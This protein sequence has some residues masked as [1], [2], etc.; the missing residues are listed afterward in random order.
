MSR[1]GTGLT[2]MTNGTAAS[3]TDKPLI[4]RTTGA[5]NVRRLLV[6][7]GAVFFLA[8]FPALLGHTYGGKLLLAIFA[9]LAIVGVVVVFA[10]ALGLVSVA[11]QPGQGSIANDFL[12][13]LDVGTLIVDRRGRIVYANT[14]YGRTVGASD[15]AEIRT[16]ERLLS[17]EREASEAIYRLA[18]LARDNR[19]GQ[20]EFRLPRSLAD[21]G[22]PAP[23]WY[24]VSVRP[25]GTSPNGL[26]AWQ[27]ADV[28][29]ERDDQETF[30]QDLQHAIDYLD[31]APAGFFAADAEGRIA[32]INATL[33]DWLGVDLVSFRPYA[34]AISEFAAGGDAALLSTST[35]ATD[36]DAVS[37][38]DLDLVRQ[39]GDRLPVRLLR[40]TGLLPDGAPGLSR[41]I[42]LQRNLDATG[43]GALD[44]AEV[45]FTRFF[46]SSPMAIAALG[47]DGRVL[48]ANAAFA[49][50]FGQAAAG[51]LLSVGEAVRDDSRD[52]LRQAL[53]AAGRQEAG[54][55]AVDVDLAG[56]PVRCARLYI[57]ATGEAG[58]GSG[59]TAILYGVDITDQRSLE[60][61]FAKSQK[62]QAVG[63]LAGG[64]AHDFN[65][66]LTIITASVDF[67]L[68]NH[69]SG[70]P[71]FQDLLLIKQSA[72]RA[73]SLVR[74]LLA[75]SR[76]QTMRPKMLNLTDVIADM[77]LLLKRI[78]G[79]L[80]K[81]ERHH[82]R[83][84]WP[85]MAD[86]G[87][88]EQVI[89]N[90]VQNARDAMPDGGRIQIST[91]NVSDAEA[92]RFGY[93]EMQGGDH[94]L[95]EVMDSGTGMPAD[96]AERIFEPFFTTK[97]IGKG[98]GLGLSMVYGIVKQS[99]GFIFVDSKLGQGTTFRIFLPRH[100]PLELPV[101]KAEPSL[102]AEQA[103]AKADLSGTASILLV[104]DEDHVRAGNVRA[105][106]MRGYEVHEASSGVEALE[107]MEEI[108]G[109]IDLVVSDV[110]MPEMDGPTLLR[111]M[112]AKRPDLK[113]IFV[114]GYA[115]D[116]FAKNLPEGEKFG[117]LAKPFSLRDLAIAVKDMLDE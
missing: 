15:P 83:D 39:D 62:M 91:R 34:R 114:S 69:R 4:D 67:L 31:H 25:L 117:F 109:R 40:K 99:G 87:Q 89:T 93:A 65:N 29:A 70:D 8:A 6:L 41:T 64:I 7:C 11:G 10:A 63:N 104:E 59:D 71:S 38:V 2:S 23:R 66:V 56:E 48:R 97:E 78:S 84:L 110:V 42:V 44:A 58:S 18:N 45:R 108:G 19:S 68:L 112:R 32:Y 101:A 47:E 20:E 92:A 60:E 52:A 57:S 107:V 86:I 75:Y 103:A 74:Q 113:F 3:P 50:M 22:D 95:V 85:V 30:F 72:N 55:P 27:I 106:K 33:A 61:Q 111:E 53:L 102:S 81:L 5:R 28:T 36:P 16:I 21:A 105:L 12:D 115:E 98:T 94:V 9:L 73:A 37:V 49:R 82:A 54:I 116:A 96:V 88:F 90:L 26:H 35:G 46:N 24:R 13:T 43:A 76:R 17:R 79:D 80:V 1:L 51:G 14:A 100:I 77:H